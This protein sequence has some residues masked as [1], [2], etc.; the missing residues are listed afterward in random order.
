MTIVQPDGAVRQAELDR[1]VTAVEEALLEE[2]G[3]VV[4]IEL[5]E[6]DADGVAALCSVDGSPDA[7]WVSGLGYAAASA[8]DCAE[9]VLMV[10]RGAGRQVSISEEVQIIVNDEFEASDVGG[11]I[12]E[13]FCRIG[14]D[15]IFT[16]LVP[17]LILRTGGVT[18]LPEAFDVDD[19]EALIQ[20]VA[21]GDN[22]VA[23]GLTAA[24]FEQ[25]AGDAAESVRVLNRTAAIPYAVLMLPPQLPLDTRTRLVDALLDMA[26][27]D[28]LETLLE[29]DGLSRVED[30]SLDEFDSFVRATNIDFAQLGSE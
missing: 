8:Q 20:S 6:S 10:E 29:Q 28:D 17:T 21:D 14:Y 26:E 16:W 5:V 19:V 13:T 2:S 11:L 23:G 22:C 9:P 1:A 27:S 25:F 15:D 4:E 30:D 7:A 3:L 12:E 24:D 18:D